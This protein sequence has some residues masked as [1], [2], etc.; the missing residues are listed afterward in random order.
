MPP[1]ER[2]LPDRAIAPKQQMLRS[3]RVGRAK[4]HSWLPWRSAIATL[5]SLCRGSRLDLGS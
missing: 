5:P 2:S 1:I 4:G 3:S